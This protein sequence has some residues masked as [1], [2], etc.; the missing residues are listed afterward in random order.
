MLI[1]QFVECVLQIFDLFNEQVIEFKIIDISKLMGLS[2]SIF[3]LLLKILQFY[4]YID[5]NLENGKYCFG[6]K[7]VECGYFVV[8]FIDIWQKV[9]GWLMELFWWIG[10]IIYLGILDGCE[11]VYIEKI[12]G[13]LVVIV[14]LRI[15][16]RLLVYVIVIGKVLI[17]WLGEVELN[18][19]L[20]GYQ[21]IIFMFVIFVFC[22]VLMSVL[23]QIC[24]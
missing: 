21:Y 4:G 20:E 22:E 14:Y 13:K 12:E 11:G 23:V 24:E 8:G 10:Q 1:I 5:Q 6:M 16:R 9:K 15:G 7:L 3:Y 19:L 18:V 2:K 17:V